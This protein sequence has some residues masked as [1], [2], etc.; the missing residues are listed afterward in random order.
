MHPPPNFFAVN[1]AIS[2]LKNPFMMLVL[3]SD[4]LFL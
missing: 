3:V 2:V 4:L 1:P